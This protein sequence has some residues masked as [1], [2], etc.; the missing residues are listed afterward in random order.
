MICIS[1]NQLRPAFHDLFGAKGL[2]TRLCSDYGKSRSF[3]ISM[4]SMDYAQTC[5]APGISFY[6]SVIE[7]HI[8]VI[9]IRLTHIGKGYGVGEG[10]SVVDG[11]RLG[12][13]LNFGVA[14]GLTGRAV[15]LG[16]YPVGKPVM[17]LISK[18]VIDP[19][20]TSTLL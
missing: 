15:G 5:A 4:R 7:V 10:V 3:D 1:Q 2:D 19:V 12:V 8:R 13:M 17:I 18:P 14:V 20:F 9:I 11:V 16:T 6:F